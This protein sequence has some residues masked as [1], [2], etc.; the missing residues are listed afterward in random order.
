MKRV[1]WLAF[2]GTAVLSVP[3]LMA[4]TALWC[5]SYWVGDYLRWQICRPSGGRLCGSLSQRREGGI[6]DFPMS[7]S[8]GRR[9]EIY[10]DRTVGA[11]RTSSDDM[12]SSRYRL[13]GNQHFRAKQDR[14]TTGGTECAALVVPCDSL[15]G[16][17]A[18]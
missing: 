15:C 2:Y 7:G 1:F 10:G 16:S 12:P 17:F 3:L 14:L 6:S 18:S 9:S 8:I 13:P 4:T 11:K 5:R